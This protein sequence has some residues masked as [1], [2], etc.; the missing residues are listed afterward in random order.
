VKKIRFKGSKYTFN[1]YRDAQVCA[2]IG[3]YNNIRRNL[4]VFLALPKMEKIKYNSLILEYGE[5]NI[6]NR[7]YKKYVDEEEDEDYFQ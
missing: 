1:N 7:L 5:I 2:A 3:G 6:F 4:P